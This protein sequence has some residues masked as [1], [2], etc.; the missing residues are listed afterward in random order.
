MR[1]VEMNQIYLLLLL[2][3]VYG[4]ITE[5]DGLLAGVENNVFDTDNDRSTYFIKDELTNQI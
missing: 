2:V 3:C 1:V 4:F 5:V